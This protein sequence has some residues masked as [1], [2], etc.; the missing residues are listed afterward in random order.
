MTPHP[1]QNIRPATLARSTAIGDESAAEFARLMRSKGW[2][3][4]PA[5]ASHDRL[6]H[7]DF[8]CEKDG[9]KIP[10]DV[11]GRKAHSD[12]HILIE[13]RGIKGHAGS[14]FGEGFLAF[15]TGNEFLLIP[16]AALF[17]RL[18]EKLG[19]TASFKGGFNLTMTPQ[20]TTERLA[21]CPMVY[22]RPDRAEEMVTF[23]SL[24]EARKLAVE[25]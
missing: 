6:K 21:V 1:L 2:K 23:L 7:V 12:T 24:E 22:R 8:Y 15:H 14:L 5:P 3:V 16:R 20:W 11:K 19:F 4:S 17:V 25:F 10:V 13:I 9:K 18:K